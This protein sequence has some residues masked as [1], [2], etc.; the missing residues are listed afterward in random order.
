MK[1]ITE[2]TALAVVDTQTGELAATTAQAAA[3]SE[4][5]SAIIIAR[6]FPRNE[7]AC[8]QKLMRACQRPA[9]AEDVAY[10]FPRG[11]KQ[12]DRGAWVKNYVTGPSVYLAREAARLW[13]NIRYGVEVVSDSDDLRVVRGWAWD[14][15]TNVKVSSEDS[16]KKLIQRKVK[17]SEEGET[18]WI[19]PDE[20]DLR[21]L[22]NRRAAIC[23]RNCLL[24][25]LPSDLVE[26][27]LAAAVATGEKSAAAD[28]EAA[29]KKVVT[30]FGSLNVPVEALEAYLGHK[31]AECSP[32]ELADLR[33]IWKSISDGASTWNEYAKPK[34]PET[35]ILD[36]SAIKPGTEPN[37]GHEEANLGKPDAEFALGN[38][39]GAPAP[40]KPR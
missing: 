25:L 6:K 24:Q 5:Q 9:F 15:E 19:A 31:V 36:P 29:R 10:S 32:K 26:D 20:R 37:R 14:L 39:A 34:A 12:D 40:K 2:E 7:D 28:P 38:P 27:A 17:G 30:A 1:K 3:Q 13:G 8:F 33:Q 21:E 4:I 23:T 16:F 35:G 22:T 18:I 11:K